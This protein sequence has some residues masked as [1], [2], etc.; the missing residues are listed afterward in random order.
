[1]TDRS[2]MAA[3]AHVDAAVN[4]LIWTVYENKRNERHWPAL[5]RQSIICRTRSIYVALE[6]RF[7]VPCSDNESIYHIV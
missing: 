4:E 3:A 5:E 6:A 7:N 2:G 1:M